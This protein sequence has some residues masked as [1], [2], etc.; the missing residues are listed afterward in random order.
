MRKGCAWSKAVKRLPLRKTTSCCIGWSPT[1]DELVVSG[2]F[3]TVEPYAF[4]LPKDDKAFREIVDKTM[5]GL[6]QSGE[7]VVIYKK[8]FDNDRMRVPMNI[9]MKENIRFPSRYGVP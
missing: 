5:L 7:F 8:W 2:K 9:Y 6:M 3:L 1:K 4:M